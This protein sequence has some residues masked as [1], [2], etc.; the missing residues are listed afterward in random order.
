[1][2][3]NKLTQKSLEAVQSAQ[4]LAVEN[5]NQQVQQCHLFLA[6]LQQEDGLIGQLMDRMGVPGDSLASALSGAVGALPKIS[7]SNREADK[8]YVSQGLDQALTEAEAQA[9]RMKDD[10]VSVEHLVLGMLEKPE[11]DVKKLMGTFEIDA[12]RFLAALRDV[13]GNARV[14]RR[15]PMMS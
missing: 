14:T 5:G 1:M 11:A 2:N 4:T 8:I 9:S 6:L 3:L 13:R 7:G 15:R 10:Y 12:A